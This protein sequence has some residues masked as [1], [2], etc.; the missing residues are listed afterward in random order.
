MSNIKDLETLIK[1]ITTILVP[2]LNKIKI[3]VKALEDSI[4]ET[5][6]CMADLYN[7]IDSRLLALESKNLE[8][9]DNIS[10]ALELIDNAI[11]KF[12]FN[13]LDVKIPLDAAIVILKVR[14]LLAEEKQ[15]IDK[16]NN[17]L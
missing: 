11:L 2:G 15:H 17:G 12:E 14:D 10:K 6:Q 4:D 7:N 8:H 1:D 16:K 9:N 13:I 3:N 5:D